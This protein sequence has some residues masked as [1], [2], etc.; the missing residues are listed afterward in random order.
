MAQ[1]RKWQLSDYQSFVLAK[2]VLGVSEYQ[3]FIDAYRDWYGHEPGTRTIDAEFGEY[4]RSNELPLYVRHFARRFVAAHPDHVQSF[5]KVRQRSERAHLI[6]IGTLALM[7]LS[8]LA[9]A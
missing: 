3:L 7:V 9:L 6:A 8:A 2:E 5:Q 4:L 1:A